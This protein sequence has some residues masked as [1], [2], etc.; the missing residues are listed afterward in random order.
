[1]LRRLS[2]THFIER[3]L[4]SQSIPV[5]DSPR[6]LS[7]LEP[8]ID[9][10]EH[11]VSIA[12]TIDSLCE[13]SLSR[14]NRV[15]SLKR[16]ATIPQQG[17]SPTALRDV[18]GASEAV[19]YSGL[20][21]PGGTFDR[22]TVPSCTDLLGDVQAMFISEPLK[23]GQVFDRRIPLVVRQDDLVDTNLRQTILDSISDSVPLVHNLSCFLLKADS[24]EGHIFTFV[25]LPTSNLDVSAFLLEEE[26]PRLSV[27]SV[28]TYVV[29][30]HISVVHT[31]SREISP[32]NI[33]DMA[34][35][36]RLILEVFNLVDNS[37]LR[38]QVFQFDKATS[39]SIINRMA[40]LNRV[41]G[42]LLGPV[43][44][45]IQF[46]HCFFVI[47]SFLEESI[48][49]HVVVNIVDVTYSFIVLHDSI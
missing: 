46:N 6:L 18:P 44:D 34:H 13:A 14:C 25:D 11:V 49:I 37:L 39:S 12:T 15:Q 33:A 1:M 29:A 9:S 41:I 32:S 23:G 4:T 42:N 38:V 17:R 43:E 21:S 28:T 26:L 20:S 35:T 36:S 3:S 31:T 5:G 30:Q 27:L 45:S 16:F 48:S 40:F 2:I 19:S 8:A 10:V 7:S 24:H 22:L 47:D